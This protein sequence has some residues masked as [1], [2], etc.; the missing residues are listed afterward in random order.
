[1][2]AA[3]MAR[4]VSMRAMA[5][6]VFTLLMAITASPVVAQPKVSQVR[7]A[8][9]Y[10][11]STGP[12][13]TPA[14][15]GT[16]ASP[17]QSRGGRWTHA[18]FEKVR[19]E[20][21]RSAHALLHDRHDAPLVLP[22][23]VN[24]VLVGFDGDGGYRY[25]ADAEALETFLRQSFGHF[26]PSSM[27]T[28]RPL[29]VSIELHYNVVHAGTDHLRTIESAISHS[30]EPA[31]DEPP[32][33]PWGDVELLAKK[34]TNDN[35]N[36][37]NNNDND[38]R[39][40]AYEVEAAGPVENAV[41]FVYRKI[42]ASLNPT[43]RNLEPVAVFV[44]NPDKCRMDPGKD[45]DA[46][47]WR[48][49]S[50]ISRA[51]PETLSPPELLAE[52]CGYA[53]RYRYMDG[54]GASA[55]WVGAGR[56][57]VLDLG[58]GPAALT[59]VGRGVGGAENGGAAADGTDWG[60]AATTTETSLPRLGPLLLPYA[61]YLEEN[62][63]ANE[64]TRADLVTRRDAHMR[65]RLSTLVLSSV[66]HLL[67]PDV[68]AETLDFA[69]RVMVPV[70]VLRDHNS[71]WPLDLESAGPFRHLDVELVK[72]EAKKMLQPGQEIVL[73]TGTHNLHEHKRLTAAVL[74]S[75]RTSSRAD[76]RNAGSGPGHE[77]T[78][79]VTARRY[80]DGATLLEEFRGSADLLA[81]G[82][83]GLE[84]PD[85][86]AAFY[87]QA[88]R[89]A[90]STDGD[91]ELVGDTNQRRGYKP[92]PKQQHGTRV[93]PVYVLS[94]AGLPPGVLIDGESMVA[95]ADDLVIVL[96]G[97]GDPKLAAPGAEQRGAWARDLDAESEAA[98]A[99]LAE[100]AE[101]LE[102]HSAGHPAHAS[103]KA[104]AT[105]AAAKVAELGA[106]R[107]EW[108]PVRF[109]SN[110]RLV[111]ARPGEP[112]R[113]VVAGV[114]R[115]LGG[116]ASPTERWSPIHGGVV[117]NWLWAVG[118]HP[119]GP[120]SGCPTMSVVLQDV[121]KRNAA[122]TRVDTALRA[123]R[124]GIAEIEAFGDEFLAS[125]FRSLSTDDTAG[126]DDDGAHVVLKSSKGTWLDYLYRDP[127][128][129]GPPGPLPQSVV[130]QLEK[131]LR[132]VETAFV[133]LGG[134]LYNHDLDEAH[135]AS[136]TILIAAHAF[137]ARA[138]DEVARAR[139]GL[140][141]CR[142]EHS[143]PGA[144][145]ERRPGA[146]PVVAVVGAGAYLAAAYLR[147]GSGGRGR[148][149]GAL[150]DATGRGRGWMK[151]KRRAHAD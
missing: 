71:F 82:L 5:L 151:Y 49:A 102:M 73:M 53:Y 15:S 9:I 112:T 120:F 24:I 91:D 97:V 11:A 142:A 94:L 107:G 13:K 81:S 60:D 136:S 20:V 140:R 1:M 137:E 42:F 32:P 122:L 132:G 76:R 56:Y 130:A 148:V 77:H 66:R 10:K 99:E 109:A 87:A 85:L 123:V 22:L 110:D 35:N 19:G 43:V 51:P 108:V 79:H 59:R 39:W 64:G 33:H 143:R 84:D 45:H 129:V 139:H 75:L 105:A 18:L 92:K 131:E 72:E 31:D 40:R 47:D 4:V 29:E 12:L 54:E 119:F 58:A 117:E 103:V 14:G 63:D 48:D 113:H 25:R 141:C 38:K 26:R 44:L 150:R 124:A 90:D 111:H 138:R 116:V 50:G 147:G 78:Y 37:D 55:A 17:S 23:E 127:K 100:A 6:I 98:T 21:Q 67:A 101:F 41:D 7:P 2:A 62:G 121:A 115:A 69:E 28:G 106:G 125:P 135:S 3:A 70:I 89:L 128:R 95:A 68:A 83:V 36:N 46:L 145:R 118:H 16:K 104:A 134:K 34:S 144:A 149:G 74:R 86:D 80:L 96:Q 65:G 133:D 88:N 52:E 114:A 146:F 27:S 30:A 57:A 8:R 126:D 61:R 93:V